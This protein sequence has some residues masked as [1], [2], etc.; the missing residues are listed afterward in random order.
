MLLQIESYEDEHQTRF[1]AI[2]RV[3]GGAARV[4]L[5]RLVCFTGQRF[6]NST[7]SYDLDDAEQSSASRKKMRCACMELAWW[8]KISRAPCA[9][10]SKERACPITCWI[11]MQ[12]RRSSP[13][14]STDG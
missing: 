3:N 10:I 12:P 5:H 2:V 7:R 14:G 8:P 9:F 13:R 1:P 4:L 6:L 11:Y